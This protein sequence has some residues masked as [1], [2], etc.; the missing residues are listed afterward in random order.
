MIQNKKAANNSSNFHKSY[1]FWRACVEI[2]PPDLARR[3]QTVL[4]PYYEGFF[5]T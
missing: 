4:K 1:I 3:S 2:E 5:M